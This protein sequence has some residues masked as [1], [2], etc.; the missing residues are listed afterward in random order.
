MAQSDVIQLIQIVEGEKDANGVSP[1]TD[2]ARQVFCQVK[3][4]KQSEFFGAGRNGLNPAYCFEVFDGDYQNET[5]VEYKGRRYAIY[6]TY[7]IP[8]TQRLELYTE[9]KGGT[10]GKNGKV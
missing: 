1:K 5:I 9:R 10:N 2:V 4:V 8:G 6:R 7:L 3:S